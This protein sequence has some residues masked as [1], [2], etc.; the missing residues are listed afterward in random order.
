[1]DNSLQIGKV[2]IDLS[3]YSGQDF[4]SEGEIEDKL[5][6]V[7]ET[8][9]RSEFRKTIENNTSWPYL[10]HFSRVRENIVSW[11]PLKKTDK[12][13][14]VGAGMGA[15]TNALC[16]KSGQ[17]TSVDLSLKRSKVNANRNKDMDN[18]TIKVGNFTDI[19]ADLDND[20]DWIM[21]IGVFEYAISY[22]GTDNPFEDFLKILMKHLKQE[23]RL[24]IAIENRLGMKYFAGC[25]E[26]HTCGFFDGIENYHKGG[27]VRT[28][29][30]NGLENIFKKVNITNY[31][32]YYPYPDYKL[33][34]TI[35][36]DKRLPSTGELRDNMRNFDQDRIVLFDETNAYDGMIEEGL[37]PTFSNSYE[38]I[39]GPDVE[40]EYAKYSMD[41]DDKYCICTVI[42]NENGV[43]KVIKA[44]QTPEASKH[45]NML[46]KAYTELC[47]R[48]HFSKLKINKVLKY[49]EENAFIEFEY[50]DGRTLEN[51]LDEKVHAGD[52]EG[53]I[54]LFEQFRE[55]VH[56]NDDYPVYDSDMIF[57]NII[58]K[59]DEWT[60]VDYEW[61]NFTKGS[62]H[63]IVY[64]AI[65]NYLLP[66]N[67]RNIIKEWIDTENEFDENLFQERIIG[68]NKVMS[69]IRHEIGKGVYSLDYITDRVA[70]LNMRVQIYED[71]GNGFSEDNSY[72]TEYKKNGPDVLVEAKLKNS[73]KAL[74][75]DPGDKPARIYVNQISLNDTVITDRVIGSLKNGCLNPKNVIQKD[76]VIIYK[77]A[78]PHFR[79]NLK[80]LDFKDGDI[81]KINMRVEY[82]Y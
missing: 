31:H 80:G 67:E 19:E 36:S 72:F 68:N 69:T 53:F 60:L 65:N 64:R 44:A 78:D 34:N 10:Y 13:L 18:L 37:F 30:R 47:E 11:L 16:Q 79:I 15:I 4:Y 22:M 7:A 76:N 23:G 58:I 45:I 77:K 2:N 48:F 33:P 28:F 5:L 66:G 70:G 52:K 26:D 3:K 32:F 12:V 27:Q 75:I 1:M 61:V 41:R 59:D 74:R 20:F 63:E 25:K 29:S 35:F 71:S 9:D 42:T 40:P 46:N 6:E 21:L 62:A 57:S 56:Y 17:V 49:D 82:I 43:K 54:K 8:V 51:I 24:V 81:L 39:I 73:L 14:E 50:I 38:V 55:L